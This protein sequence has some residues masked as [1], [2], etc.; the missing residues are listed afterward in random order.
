M[1]ELIYKINIDFLLLKIG[2][3]LRTTTSKTSQRY[4]L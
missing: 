2:Q 1:K 3:L 4:P